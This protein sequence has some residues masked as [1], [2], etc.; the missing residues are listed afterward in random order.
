MERRLL[1][2]EMLVPTMALVVALAVGRVLQL[3]RGGQVVV[4]YSS[5]PRRLASSLE[6]LRV[7]GSVAGL[8]SGVRACEVRAGVAC[9]AIC[10][11]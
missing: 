11:K 5:H 4:S 8:R 6:E 1:Q 3:S 10:S 9:N 7:L 2:A